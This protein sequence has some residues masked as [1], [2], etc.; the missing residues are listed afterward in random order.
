M[1]SLPTASRAEAIDGWHDVMSERR[2]VSEPAGP[3]ST[4]SVEPYVH[5]VVIPDEDDPNLPQWGRRRFCSC[6][7]SHAEDLHVQW[8]EH[9]ERQQVSKDVRA[10]LA[11]KRSP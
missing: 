3:S 5:S 2:D 9:Q 1:T 4:F 7:Y 10:A 8:R 6:F 11:R